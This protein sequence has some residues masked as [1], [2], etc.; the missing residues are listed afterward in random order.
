[1]SSQSL[2]LLHCVIAVSKFANNTLRFSDLFCCVMSVL[3][4]S[5][6]SYLGEVKAISRLYIKI[7]NIFSNELDEDKFYIKNVVLEVI[8]NFAVEIFL[9]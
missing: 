8:Y 9:N 7:I 3:K 2:N 6:R 5:S 1:M 4:L